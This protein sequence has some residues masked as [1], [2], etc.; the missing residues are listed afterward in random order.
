[1]KQS[2]I[3][4]FIL[5]V[6]VGLFKLLLTLRDAPPQEPI[7]KKAYP[8]KVLEVIPSE[9]S[10]QIR[11]Y[12]TVRPRKEVNVIPEVTGKIVEVNPLLE[13]GAVFEKGDVLFKIDPTEYLA[14]VEIA[15]GTLARA[16]LELEIERGNQVVAKKEWELLKSSDRN[17]AIASPDLALRKPH[18]RERLAAVESAKASLAVAKLNLERST[19]RAPFTCLVVATSVEV[20]Q[21]VQAGFAMNQG[22]ANNNTLISL[23]SSKSFEVEVKIPREQSQWFFGKSDISVQL[24]DGQKNKYSGKYIGF[25]GD[26]DQAGKQAKVL[27]EII[28]PLTHSPP[29]L[30]N[31]FVEVVLTGETLK[32]TISVPSTAVR[33]G[34]LLWTL[35]EDS[36]LEY[37]AFTPVYQIGEEVIGRTDRL[38][39]FRV[40]TSSIDIPLQGMQLEAIN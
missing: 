30:L 29:L 13:P 14:G 8:V 33:E 23:V 10:V 34:D 3:A 38:E 21:F 19:L 4:F 27:V 24:S 20:G 31:T 12:G 40:V 16:E 1:M 7:E 5:L 11:G 28:N 2:L 15:K 36:T 9:R 25:Y 26:L 6:S 32:N 22:A 35:T 39:A 18:L 37:L 17:V